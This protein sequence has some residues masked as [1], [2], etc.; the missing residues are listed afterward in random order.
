M[1]ALEGRVIKWGRRI[2]RG[3]VHILVT[4]RIFTGTASTLIDTP[5]SVG[6]LR[7]IF[8]LS[9][10]IRAVFPVIS[11]G[12]TVREVAGGMRVA[13]PVPVAVVAAAPSNLS[14]RPLLENCFLR[15]YTGEI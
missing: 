7:V 6:A 4:P 1:P 5:V 10:T 11:M 9:V 13:Y 15:P 8:I 14:L 3:N 2:P 12:N